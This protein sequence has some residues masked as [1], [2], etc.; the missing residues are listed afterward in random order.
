MSSH[1]NKPI[2]LLNSDDGPC[3]FMVQTRRTMKH[4]FPIVLLLLLGSVKIATAQNAK[5]QKLLLKSTKTQ[6]TAPELTTAM[7]ISDQAITDQVLKTK[8]K[9]WYQRGKVY[10]LVY[11]SDVAVG[12]IDK[13]MALTRVHDALTQVKK[14]GKAS[15]SYVILAE[16]E[17]VN[18]GSLVMNKGVEAYTNQDLKK[19]IRYFEQTATLKPRDTIGYLYAAMVAGELE[20]YTIALRNYQ[21]LVE[22]NPKSEYYRMIISIQKDIQQDPVAAMK[23]VEQAKAKLGDNN[24]AIN[25]MEID[26]L[27]ANGRLEEA[28][29]ELEKTI[30][31]E[32]NNDFLHLRKGLLFDQLLTAENTKASP[33]QAQMEQWK[34][35][36]KAAYK[37]TIELNNNNAM[38]YFNLGVLISSEANTIYK[39]VNEL[40]MDDYKAKGAAMEAKAKSY[41]EEAVPYMEAAHKIE[42]KEAYV[43]QALEQFYARLERMED[44]KKTKDKLKELGY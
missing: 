34:E 41:I 28:L 42:P 40:S 3:T 1:D 6:L 15:D 44:Y 39:E 13:D 23:S 20:D 38:A 17:Y 16:T 5:L 43:L 31:V 35:A 18:L 2:A 21:Q 27:I 14:L 25:K 30:A 22:L 9:T 37:K 33:N 32:P 26:L 36:A 24:L 12:G 8:P 10:S 7:G 4:I 11:Q 29:E 19:A